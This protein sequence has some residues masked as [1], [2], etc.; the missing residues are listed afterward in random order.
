MIL[1]FLSSEGE[2]LLSTYNIPLSLK[3]AQN[4]QENL[5]RPMTLT[6]AVIF[7]VQLSEH[8]SYKSS[9][10]YLKGVCGDVINVMLSASAWNLNKLIMEF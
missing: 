6:E 3:E 9:R 5:G 1:D 2:A 7:G 8:C 4:L 10:N